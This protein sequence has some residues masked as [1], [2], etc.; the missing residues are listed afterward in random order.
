MCRDLV[1]CHD[2]FLFCKVTICKAIIQ[3]WLFHDEFFADERKNIA[4]LC[5]YMI[6][7]CIFASENWVLLTF[8]KVFP[9]GLNKFLR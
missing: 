6:K 1:D 9:I 4:F 2:G 3:D 8:G 7:M 5:L